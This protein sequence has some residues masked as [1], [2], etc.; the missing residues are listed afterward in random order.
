MSDLDF[1]FTRLSNQILESMAKIKLSPT[2]YRILFVVWRF[3]YG[4]QRKTHQLS[5]TFLAEATECD[6]RLI[7]R[8]LKKLIEL[9]ILMVKQVKSKTRDIG[10]NKN[11]HQWKID[12]GKMDIGKIDNGETSNSSHG[13]IDNDSIG[14]IDNQERNKENLKEK[15]IYILDYWNLKGIVK[16]SSTD[17]MLKQIQK[18]LKKYRKEDI[19]KAIDNYAA[20]YFDKNYYYSH[21][22]RLDK[23]LRQS[24]GLSDFLEDGQVWLNYSSNKSHITELEC[25]PI[26]NIN[27]R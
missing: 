19:L 27:R 5:L 2:Q 13:E 14:K 10:F 11:I 8:E 7:Q 16:H 4:F 24:N 22:W 9:N 21:I 20:I 15:Y 23:F 1:G 6:L 3:T 12:N 25:N 17:L 18:A 26:F